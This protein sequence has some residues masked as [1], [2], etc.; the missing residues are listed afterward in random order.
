[1]IPIILGVLFFLMVAGVVVLVTVGIYQ[2][3][4]ESQARDLAWKNAE[5]DARKNAKDAKY[6]DSASCYVFKLEDGTNGFGKKHEGFI[7][8]GWN[9]GLSGSQHTTYTS[10]AEVAR[11]EFLKMCKARVVET[12]DGIMIP[13]NRIKNARITKVKDL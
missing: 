13:L 4:R 3:V 12:E 1:M 8:N 7:F 11:A 2:H 5:D 9:F 6:A 10:S